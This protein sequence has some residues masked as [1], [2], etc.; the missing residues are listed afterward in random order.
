MA[1]TDPSGV[2]LGV[3]A[4][5]LAVA[6]IFGVVEATFVRVFVVVDVDGAALRGGR[7][8]V[9]ADGVHCVVVVLVVAAAATAVRV[10][11]VV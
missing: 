9:V 5:V 3:A 4:V 1:A 2:R 8:V 6:L 10:T 7:V 11:S